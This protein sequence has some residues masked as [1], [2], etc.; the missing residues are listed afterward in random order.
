MEIR[1]WNYLIA[2]AEEKSISKAAERLFMA[3]SSLSQFLSVM[4]SELGCRLFVRTSTGVRPTEEGRLMT[5]YAYRALS[6]YHSVRDQM[7]DIRDLQRGRV[8][9]GISSFRGSFLMPPVLNAFHMEYPGIRV[10]IREEN[11]MVLE[12]LLQ[13]GEIDLAL[14]V[15]P[16]TDFKG[17]VEPLM[18][19]EIC[20]ITRQGH[21]VLEKTRP[22]PSGSRSKI[23]RCIDVRDTMEYEYLLSDYD[24][25]LGREARRIFR[26]KG[27]TPTAHNE[28]LS[29][30]FAAS[31]GAAGLGLAFTYHSSH[32]YYPNAEY[33]S[34]GEDGKFLKLGLA[35]P[36]GRYHSRAAEA[37]KETMQRVLGE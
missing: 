12:Q 4:E 35:M 10:E 6:E 2:I 27:L 31:M 16:A 34:L 20:L 7:Q 37:L 21:P 30:F 17:V 25:I 32:R 26:E 1:E 14:L 29:A 5:E 3:Q 9:M 18:A 11:S 36:P 28:K 22:T 33:I 23:A 24:T 15:L 8:I 13:K 19:D